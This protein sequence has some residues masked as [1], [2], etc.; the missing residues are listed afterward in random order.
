MARIAVGLLAFGLLAAGCGSTSSPP[1]AGE[2]AAR[3]GVGEQHLERSKP[4]AS[5][6]AASQS[7]AIVTSYFDCD[8]RPLLDVP[9]INYA[10][11][12]AK[13]DIDSNTTEYTI[14]RPIVDERADNSGAEQRGYQYNGIVIHPGDQIR[15]QAGGCVQTGGGGKTWKRYVD[16][17]GDDAD[18]R[19]YGTISIPSGSVKALR[20]SDPNLE[21]PVETCMSTEP[22]LPLRNFVLQDNT[23]INV[24][25]I[26]SEGVPLILGYSDDD[27]SGNGYD[28]PDPGDPVQCD[29]SQSGPPA[30][31]RLTITS[32]SPQERCTPRP[33][34]FDVVSSVAPFTDSNEYP[35]NPE[36]GWQQTQDF[37]ADDSPLYNRYL[38]N[39]TSQPTYTDNVNNMM[40]GPVP[41]PGVAAVVQFFGL[42]HPES[43][44]PINLLPDGHT[45]WTEATFT[46]Y[47]AWNDHSWSDDDYNIL[48]FTH[49]VCDPNKKTQLCPYTTSEWAAGST[50]ADPEEG[51]THQLLLEFD[52]DETI[53]HF[54]KDDNWQ[55][56]RDKVDHSNSPLAGQQSPAQQF[57]DAHDI[58]ALGLF[59][60]DDVHGDAE[61][62]PV[63]ALAIDVS[64][65]DD[66]RS[67][68]RRWM[69]FIRDYGNEGFCSSQQHFI[70]AE[71]GQVDVTLDIP[72][73]E[74]EGIDANARGTVVYDKHY[75]FAALIDGFSD[76]QTFP[77]TLS[78]IAGMTQIRAT[79]PTHRGGLLGGVVY[80]TIAIQYPQ[81]SITSGDP[82][83][84]S[85]RVKRDA[86][87]GAVSADGEGED[88]DDDAFAYLG[89]DDDDTRTQAVAFRNAIYPG[90]KAV[91]VE[92]TSTVVHDV[93][94]KPARA[95]VIAQRLSAL[96]PL[97]LASLLDSI[98][99]ATGGVTPAKPG[100]CE[101]Q[102]PITVG[103]LQ[104][105]T[106]GKDGWI[107]SDARLVLAA[108]DASGSGI[109]D[110]RYSFDQ[111]NWLPYP[112]TGIPLPEGVGAV[113]FRS[114]D[115]AG[116]QED[117]RSF[118]FKKDTRA[119]MAQ[120]FASD[121]SAGIL[122]SYS[123]T[124]PAPG[125]GVAGI[126][127]QQVG[128]LGGAPVF[129]PGA[130]G[131]VTL[132]THCTDLAYWAVDTAG[133]AETP[134]RRIF[135]TTPPELRVQTSG[136]TLWPPDK[137]TVSLQLGTDVS[138]SAHDACDPNPK[139][140]FAALV[141][142]EPTSAGDMSFS[143]A[144]LCV[145]R[146]RLGT[147]S[148]RSYTA[149][150]RATDYSGNASQGTTTVEVPH[151]F[152][153]QPP[154]YDGGTLGTTCP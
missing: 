35:L 127:Y 6:P 29:A 85:Y 17:L 82:V 21:V 13:R 134:P 99:A 93:L 31:I 72:I 4:I 44:Q 79:L 128:P 131:W 65:E 129:V 81:S 7:G 90:I 86:L 141:S 12:V 25:A 137:A 143:N 100:A 14:T 56:F 115:G 133:N 28:D 89:V 51:A 87:A 66:Y 126:Y 142:N 103:S 139:I 19:Y 123:A 135:D 49:D 136:L 20:W 1:P 151:D 121:S 45:N 114:T 83:A 67:R 27:Y 104:D 76:S 132:P 77:V 144:T 108:H 34:P 118:G 15:I 30:W 61:L 60:T 97:K 42:C 150:L 109:R 124:D 2:R 10:C 119:P 3:A 145:R 94:P 37:T 52:S 18:N 71:G 116:H 26:P 152:S 55:L 107:V 125:S 33:L 58:V 11:H 106:F 96:A 140:E 120:A 91:P 88:D 122:L 147:G 98:C 78:P 48:I 16:P 23:V 43:A 84:A 154:V 36:W 68:T 24:G 74:G 153:D 53:D 9:A 102:P 54:E 46:G 92:V 101:Q 146:D 75:G 47:A 130:S 8:G 138:V 110:T 32:G 59:G 38:P 80:G 22:L 111:T 40:I 69:Y 63:H 149:T 73:F 112:S 57:I 5:G 148:G 39:E 95:P 50:K 105:A 117:L 113:Y 70:G 41:A 64:T 62:H